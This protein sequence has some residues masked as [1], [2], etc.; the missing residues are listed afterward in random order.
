MGD[1]GVHVCFGST[2]GLLLA[3]PEKWYN[4]NVSVSM[5]QNRLMS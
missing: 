3:I 1:G 2:V 4:A 5:S